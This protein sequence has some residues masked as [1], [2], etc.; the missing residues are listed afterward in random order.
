MFGLSTISEAWPLPAF[1]WTLNAMPLVG[2]TP[3]KLQAWIY[4]GAPAQEASK[5]YKNNAIDVLRVQY[6]N[7]LDNGTLRRIDEDPKNLFDTQNAFSE[8]NVKEIKHYSSEQLVTVSGHINGMRA[9]NYTELVGALVSFVKEH[10]LTGIDIDFE[11]YNKWTDKDY[12][13][14][15]EFISNLGTELKQAD[16]KLAICGPMWT[17]EESPFKWQYADFVDLPVNYVTPMVYDYQWDYGGG[18]PICPLSWLKKW[19]LM[20]RN[21][22]S[23]ERLVIGIPSYA[24]S[25]T[26]GKFNIKNLTLKQVKNQ[27]GYAGAKRDPSSAE[28]V[29]Y[30]GNK[31][32]VSNDKHSMNAKRQVLESVGIKQISVWHLGGNAWF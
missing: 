13:G 12:K 7:L 24:Y 22:F 3:T 15:K 31:V 25:A 14:Y 11:N 26:R 20:M 28:M 27:G 19:G 29:K 30:V 17:S 1:N 18:W 8:K 16:K 21:I 4:Y 2:T 5:T 32:Y 6:F 9:T 23:D 10:E